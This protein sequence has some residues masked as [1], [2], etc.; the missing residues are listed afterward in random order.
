[1]NSSVRTGTGTELTC[2]TFLFVQPEAA[3]PGEGSFGTSLDAVFWFTADA[4]IDLFL[5]GPVRADPDP[6]TFRSNTSSVSHGT[7]DLTD[8]TART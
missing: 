4:E 7:N 3:I 2:G 5:F 8:A 1:M 6:R